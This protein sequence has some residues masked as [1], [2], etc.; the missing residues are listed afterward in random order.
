MYI[1]VL[2]YGPRQLTK[3]AVNRARKLAGNGNTIMVVPASPVGQE[4]TVSL[5]GADVIEAIG[6]EGLRKAFSQL[7]N[8][9]TLLIHD[10]VVLTTKGIVAL[11]RELS[12][13]SRYAIPY[14]NDPKMDH[15]IGS[16]PAGKA[17]ERSLDRVP[18]PQVS[19]EATLIRPACIAAKASDLASL[20]SD[21]VADPYASITPKTHGFTIAAGA[22]ASHSTQ[23]LHRLADHQN[24]ESPLLVASIIVKDEEEMLPDCLASLQSVCDRIEVCDTGSSDDTIS[25]AREFGANVI[26]MEWTNDFAAAR[27]HV[28]EQCRDAQY[29]L[30][31]DADER[32]VCTDSERTRRYLATYAAE[33]PAFKLEITNR[34]AD[35]AETYRFASV[36]L[37]PGNGTE[38]RGALHESIHLSGEDQ[39][40]GGYR[41]DQVGID[42]YGYAREVV[43]ERD[44]GRRNLDIAEA[45]FA[46]EGDARSAIHLARS[47]SSAEQ[48]PRRAFDLLEA[49]LAEA[50]DTIAEA[51]IKSLMADRCL[52]FDDHARAFDLA[53]E[54][55]ALMPADNTARGILAAASKQLGNHDEFLEIAEAV[56][57]DPSSLQVIHVDRNRWIFQDHLV[58]AYAESGR[59]EEAVAE[60]LKLLDEDPD[61]LTSW[62]PL[63]ACLNTHY[64][65]AA[66]EL[67]VPLALQDSAG[68][69]LEPMIKTYPSGI[70][71]DFCAAYVARS[72]P[73]V[74][75]T[76]VGLLAA[77]MSSNDSAFAAIAPSAQELAPEARAGLAD[78]IASSGRPDLADKLRTEPIAINL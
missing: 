4:A 33:H 55:L 31:I 77:A 71:A 67:L 57:Q 73:V 53:A 45:Q 49:A 27:N 38:W 29:V 59:A 50:Q 23:C 28:L 7:N 76:R 65:G 25:I 37:F 51:Q 43:A 36:R 16:L 52:H 20:T 35:G 61:A 70:V 75:A 10:D 60:A 18:V 62:A 66:M 69:F 24:M 54:A 9:P 32:L 19:R 47:L 2:A 6:N 26:E 22:V 39:L 40:L 58:T 68:G 63:I 72:G 64:G 78:R 15:F 1:V 56:I 12:S 13:G 8:E 17:A 46:S 14:T 48:D 21:P 30:C 74:E 42:H 41:L 3:R 11:E 44:K 5:A 34:E